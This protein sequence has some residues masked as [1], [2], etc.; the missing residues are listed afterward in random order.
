MKK[1]KL[2]K[3]DKDIVLFTK[4]K[5]NKDGLH[6]YC[7]KCK[8]KMD[9]ESYHRNKEKRIKYSKDLKLKNTE[10]AKKC[11]I[12]V[13]KWFKDN[14]EYMSKWYKNKRETDIHYRI[15]GNM[16]ARILIAIK[17][18]GKGAKTI[19]MLGCTIEHFKQH[20]ELLFKPGMNWDNYGRKGW[21]MDHIKPC[22]LFDLSFFEQQKQCFHYT[23]IQPLWWNENLNKSA[24]YE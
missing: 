12:G 14:P 10:Y 4:R 9:L 17:T 8:S 21:H 7:K 6:I 20:L 24:K 5:E 2:C 23:N 22:S 19:E 13:K 3:E 18:N 15:L 16:R 11:R 1:C